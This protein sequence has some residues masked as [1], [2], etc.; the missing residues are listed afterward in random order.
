VFADD[1]P[2]DRHERAPALGPHVVG[3]RVVIRRLVPGETGPTGG[4][5]MTD[6]LGICESWADGV[7]VV[8]REQGDRVRI[9]TADIVSGKPVPPRPLLHRRLDAVE[10]DRLALPGWQPVES[11]RL[12][13]WVLRASAGFSS[14]GNSVLALGDPGMSSSDAVA[15]VAD[16]YAARSL[17]ARAHVHPG[18][19]EEAAFAEAGW[20]TY[21]STLLMLASVAR[22]LRRLGDAPEVE[23]R[24]RGTVDD[25]WLASDERASRH[26]EAARQVLEAGEVTLATAR[27]EDGTVLARG[28][29]AFHDDWLGVSALFTRPDVRR[30]GLGTA[31]LRSVVEWGAE[32]G[33]TTTYLQVVASNT[34]AQELYEAR[35]YEVHHRYDYLVANLGS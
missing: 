25:G 5:A 11:A 18:G 9:A 29:G 15:R 30:T 20:T 14:R 16:W 2:A 35:G 17:A 19:P 1:L 4:P 10:A 6:V 34:A 28:R 23:V 8:R 22:V 31:V 32:R 33:A 3:Q 27:D 13:D 7:V 24:H 21:E 26:G 12:G